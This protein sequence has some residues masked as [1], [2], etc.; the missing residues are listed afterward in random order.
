MSVPKYND[1]PIFINY[2]RDTVD[3]GTCQAEVLFLSTR[4][5]ISFKA[6]DCF[7]IPPYSNTFQSVSDLAVR[8]HKLTG[9]RH[10]FFINAST[11]CCV[12]YGLL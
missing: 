8:K 12:C 11:V 10:L 1:S 4:F 3:D 9:I 7:D 5:G 6:R 2:F